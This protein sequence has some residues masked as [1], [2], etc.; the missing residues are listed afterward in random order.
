MPK[1]L[2]ALVPIFLFGC[3]GALSVE[4]LRLYKLREHASEV[5]FPWLYFA[6]VLPFVIMG[7]VIAVAL[8]VSPVWSAFATGAAVEY[9]V[10]AL[11][12]SGT[13]PQPRTLSNADIA[14]IADQIADRII[15]RLENNDEEST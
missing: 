2:D 8:D 15:E 6:V 3:F 7:G 9:T 12:S 13:S 11:G 5:S 4:L 14:R 10:S 1:S